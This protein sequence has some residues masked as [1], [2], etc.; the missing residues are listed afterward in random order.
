MTGQT[1]VWQ[2]HHPVRLVFGSGSIARL[3]ELIIGRSSVLLVT[4]PGSTGRGLTGRVTKLLSGRNVTV[5]DGVTSNVELI[6]LESVTHQ[7][8][9]GEYDEIVAVGGGSAIDTAK[10]LSQTLQSSDHGA[11]RRHLEDGEHMPLNKPA[12]P[13]LTVP[14]TAGTGAEVTPFATVWDKTRFVKHSFNSGEPYPR[15]ALLD[16]EL[17]FT[18]PADVTLSTG[19]DALSQGLESLWSVGSN[20]ISIAYAQRAV[21]ISLG[22]L[23]AVIRAPDDL[24]LRVA[25]MEASLLAGLAIGIGRTTLSHSVSYPLT[26][27]FGVPHELACAFTLAQVLRFNAKGDPAGIDRILENL[28]TGTTEALADQIC[29][30]LGDTGAYR[31]MGLLDRPEREILWLAAEGITPGRSDNNPRHASV[32]DVEN[33]LAVS[34]GVAR[35]HA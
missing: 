28:G 26:L 27:H 23:S 19:L 7:L 31:Q 11:L 1:D 12:L 17:T 3:P 5:Y 22:A 33:I 9:D 29:D 4:K 24:A 21:Q 15:L 8:V 20:A 18:M 2:T 30:L 14:A 13:V 35:N 32:S 25:M 6:S 16:P 34:L 10:V